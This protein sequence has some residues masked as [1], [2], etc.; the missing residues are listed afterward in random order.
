[1][2]LRLLALVC[3][4]LMG[5][6]SAYGQFVQG[7]ND[8]GVADSVDMVLEVR[9]DA[10]T[11]QLKVQFDLWLFDDSNQVVGITMGFSWDNPNMQ[12]DS[13]IASPEITSGF[14]L[15][16]S[17]YEGQSIATTNANQ[18]FPFAASRIF[19]NGLLPDPNRRLAASYYF[20]LSNWAVSDSI[21]LD[22]LAYNSGTSFKFVRA[23]VEDYI[24]YW[25]GKEVVK[26]TAYKEPSN[27]TVAPDSLFFFAEEGGATPPAQPVSIGS[28]NDPLN[29]QLEEDASWLIKSPSFGTTPVNAN[30]SVNITALPAGTY[31]DSIQV[32]SAEAANSPQFIYVTLQ[33]VE[34]PP[35]I[36]VSPTNFFFNAIAGGSNPPTQEL[37]ISN[38]GGSTLNWTA[39]N[40]EPWL[41]LSP[42]S[43][44]DA[45]A[46]TLSVDITGLAFNEYYDTVVVS[47]PAALN[48]PVRVPVKLTV[49][50]DL[51]VIVAD[52]AFNYIIVDLPDAT[53][54]PRDF[55]ILNGGGGT[56]NFTLNTASPRISLSPTSGGAPS[57]I[58]ATFSGLAGG[59]PNTNI[60]DTV[61]VSSDEAINSPYPVVFQFRFVDV[62]AYVN[63]SPSTLTFDIYECTSGLTELPSQQLAVINGGGDNPINIGLLYESDLFVVDKDSLVPPGQFT[64]T[65]QLLDLPVGTYLDTILVTAKKAVNSPDTVFIV[66]NVLAGDEPPEMR[67]TQSLVIDPIKEEA[68]PVT[69]TGFQVNNTNPGCMS[70]YFSE[71]IPW[72]F[73]SDTSGINGEV[74]KLVLDPT[75]FVLGE[76]E[77]SILVYSDEATNSPRKVR[78]VMRIWR[79][80]GDVNWDGTLDISDLTY[81]VRYLFFDGPRPQPEYIVGDVDCSDFVDISDLTYLVERLFLNGPFPCGNPFK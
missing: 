68:G 47:D 12:M 1:M 52:S 57:T 24:P 66:Y 45:G 29:F 14:D 44:A 54:P 28:D 25:T 43:G 49:A 40:A 60:F 6:A 18:R 31:F 59:T 77:D 15:I 5:T 8:D 80:N 58:T 13:A 27:L 81:F 46:V 39:S 33:V 70:W 53:P 21:V 19:G 73:A 9:P 26:D 4:L 78:V 48:D 3:L 36:A 34:P 56:M 69:V 64:V 75:G 71:N 10:T 35:E 72:L 22:T 41:S 63:A 50:S 30:I 79:Y 37:T 7:P 23:D 42:T 16:I 2:K 38:D 20:T 65:P 51:P 62:P 67:L 17:L 55:D 11:N 74:V 61:W 76:Y 32:T